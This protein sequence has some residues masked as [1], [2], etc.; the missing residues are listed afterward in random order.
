[1]FFSDFKS[2]FFNLNKKFKILTIILFLLPI[3][4]IVGPASLEPLLIILSLFGV[5]FFLKKEVSLKLNYFLILIILFYLVSVISSLFSEYKFF[6]LKSSLPMIR[7]FISIIVISHVLEKNKWLVNYYY[8]F[9][10]CIFLFVL[11][12]GLVQLTSGYNLLLMQAKSN[13]L[14]TGFFGNEKVFGRFLF[15]FMSLLIGFFFIHK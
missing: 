15:V 1:M 12:D 3:S 5:Y 8:I 13:Y 9:I 11:I 7:F 10:L 2:N 6:S 4:L 14:I